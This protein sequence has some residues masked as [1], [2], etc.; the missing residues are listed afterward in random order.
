MPFNESRWIYLALENNRLDPGRDF[1]LDHCT[2]VRLRTNQAI[3]SLVG[4]SLKRCSVLARLSKLLLKR[5]VLV[6]PQNG[7][8]CSV[9]LVIE[10]EELQGVIGSLEHIFFSEVDPAFF[11]A[12]ESLPE[13]QAVTTGPRTRVDREAQMF[14]LHRSR[15][16]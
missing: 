6:L 2:Q 1:T 11:A 12:I 5:S 14:A 9:R 3:I 4:D 8:S 10:Q 7:E 13:R 16:A 15:F